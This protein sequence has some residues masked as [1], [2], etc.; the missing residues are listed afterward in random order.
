[1]ELTGNRLPDNS[2]LTISVKY[3]I[4]KLNNWNKCTSQRH[5]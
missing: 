2:A 3:S 1:M 4:Q 5:M